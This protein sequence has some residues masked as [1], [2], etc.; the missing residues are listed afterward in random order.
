MADAQLN[1]IYK[2][3]TAVPGAAFSSVQLTMSYYKVPPKGIIKFTKKE[4]QE[5]GN[6]VLRLRKR[7]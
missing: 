4:E 6:M 7:A 3:V 2:L 5:F 1:I